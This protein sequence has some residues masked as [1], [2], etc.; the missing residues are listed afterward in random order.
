MTFIKS[1]LHDIARDNMEMFSESILVNLHA[2]THLRNLILLFA[3]QIY[4]SYVTYVATYT[5]SLSGCNYILNSPVNSVI[6]IILA[7]VASSI[8]TLQVYVPLS[9]SMR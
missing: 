9:P 8:I 5:L 4:F 6:S 3:R 7:A 1:L 2:Q